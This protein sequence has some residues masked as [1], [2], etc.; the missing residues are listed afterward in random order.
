M[1]FGVYY[2]RYVDEGDRWR[3]Q[4]RHWSLHYRGPMDLSAPLVDSPDYGAH[5]AMPGP[6]EPTL[7][8]KI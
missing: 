8:R 2:D 5:P 3:F 7:T 4:S 6:D 1:N